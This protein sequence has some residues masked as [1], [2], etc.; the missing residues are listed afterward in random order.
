VLLIVCICVAV[1]G[2][3]MHEDAGAV[4]PPARR[5]KAWHEKGRWWP[6]RM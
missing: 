5:W 4:E 1:E 2:G 3:Q 6:R